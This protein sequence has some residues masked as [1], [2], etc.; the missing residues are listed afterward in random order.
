MVVDFGSNLAGV[1]ELTL[2]TNATALADL[3]NITLVHGEIMQH[4][5][6]PDVAA[7]DTD[8]VYTGNLR[9]ARA[10]DTFLFDAGGAA[11]GRSFRPRLTYHGFRFVEVWGW[12]EAALGDLQKS[13]SFRHFHS[14]LAPR[15]SARF[16]NLPVLD[17]ILA[18]AQGAQRSN[19]M[20]VPTDCPQRDER[21]G[22]TGDASL[23]ASSMA[24]NFDFPSFARNALD[25]LV[26][27]QATAGDG[28]V[29][30]TVS[31]KKFF[32]GTP[33]LLHHTL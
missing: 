15:T 30:D 32:Y 8:R 7:P 22:W 13:L 16:R 2:P 29:P 4:A 11:A 19:L 12:P 9:T 20:T 5:G 3:T 31:D 10:T 33:D 27:A 24:L 25:N 26:A 18:G 1:V 21:L 28:S 6:L 14:S 17:A 23:S